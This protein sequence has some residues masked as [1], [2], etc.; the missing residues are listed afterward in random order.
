MVER[1][2]PTNILGNA[3][4]RSGVLIATADLNGQSLRQQHRVSAFPAVRVSIWVLTAE[5]DLK[6]P[7]YHPGH[8]G[9][10]E[11]YYHGKSERF[12]GHRCVPWSCAGA[13]V[14]NAPRSGIFR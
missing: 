14:D 12:V 11:Q 8:M 2:N 13:R 5:L 1:R 6:C 9:N 7:R 3:F 10:P 4:T